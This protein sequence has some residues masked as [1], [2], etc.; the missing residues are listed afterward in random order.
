MRRGTTGARGALRV[1]KRNDARGP[2][3]FVQ[4]C[5][6]PLTRWGKPLV[7]YRGAPRAGVAILAPPLAAGRDSDGEASRWPD[8]PERAARVGVQR[9]GLPSCQGVGSPRKVHKVEGAK[10]R[11]SISG[12]GGG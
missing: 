4:V 1:G 8:A 3:E 11:K 9:R 6:V 10:G 5:G 12:T 2:F 7:P